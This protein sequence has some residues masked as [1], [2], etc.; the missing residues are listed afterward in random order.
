GTL[1]DGAPEPCPQ[2]SDEAQ[3]NIDGADERAMADDPHA[4]VVTSPSEAQVIASSGPAPV[5]AWSA[6]PQAHASLTMPAGSGCRLA[7]WKRV[8]GALAPEGVTWAHCPTS[9]NAYVAKV[10]DGDACVLEH[11]TG[12]TSWALSAD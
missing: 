3:S 1:P 11:A 4:P 2:V 7:W 12:H 9:G 6:P 10:I 8:L 5:F